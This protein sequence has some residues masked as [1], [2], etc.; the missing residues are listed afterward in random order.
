[1]SYIDNK[2]C[3]TKQNSTKAVCPIE[4]KICYNKR[5]ANEI[6]NSLRHH[7]YKRIRI[8]KGDKKPNRA[9]YCQ[10]CDSY[11]LTSKS[12]FRDVRYDLTRKNKQLK[13]INNGNEEF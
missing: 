9:Y 2:F 12:T 5:E 1:M 4:H 11:H 13:V 8:N 7:K 3:K 10:F 6:V